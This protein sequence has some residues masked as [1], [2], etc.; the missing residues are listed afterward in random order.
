MDKKE[1]Y[2]RKS[3]QTGLCR[4]ISSV[5]ITSLPQSIRQNKNIKGISMKN[6]EYKLACYADNILLLYL[7][8]PTDSLPALMTFEIFGQLSGYNINIGKIQ[9]L[10]YNYSPPDEIKTAGMA[11]KI[12]QVSGLKHTR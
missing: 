1:F 5:I 9:L 4:V 10:S 8:Q 12:H 3:F 2:F 11:N 7:S 6:M